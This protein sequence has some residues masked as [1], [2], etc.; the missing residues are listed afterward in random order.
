MRK[1]RSGDL[2]VITNVRESPFVTLS[3]GIFSNSGNILLG[4]RPLKLQATFKK[5]KHVFLGRFYH[6]HE[7]FF[8]KTYNIQSVLNHS[9][10]QVTRQ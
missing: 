4:S 6:F 7:I 10:I 1:M 2:G 8:S 3:C 5:C 9:S